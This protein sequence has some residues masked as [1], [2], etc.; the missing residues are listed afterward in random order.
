METSHRTCHQMSGDSAWGVARES[1]VLGFRKMSM[2]SE[3]AS[4]HREAQ[5]E[6]DLKILVSWLRGQRKPPR[7][8]C[9]RYPRFRQL[10]LISIIPYCIPTSIVLTLRGAPQAEPLPTA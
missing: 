10:V 2:L 3:T 1:R 7:M 5:R 8:Q 4:L 6:A 9:D